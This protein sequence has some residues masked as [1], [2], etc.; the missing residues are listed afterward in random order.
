[1]DMNGIR[2]LGIAL[3]IGGILALTYGGFTY[4]KDTN[5]VKLGT[6]ELSVQEKETI[7]IPLWAGLG[8]MIT[9]VLLIA[10]GDKKVDR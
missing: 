9:G 2:I 7:N 1:M 5:A 8:V 3:L 6:V 4:T 10:F